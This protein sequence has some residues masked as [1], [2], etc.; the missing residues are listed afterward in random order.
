MDVEDIIQVDTG[1]SKG[2]IGFILGKFL[3]KKFGV[4]FDDFRIPKLNIHSYGADKCYNFSIEISCSGYMHKATLTQL[5]R[6]GV[7]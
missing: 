6:G 4:K 1:I 5:I 2:I 7:K 3:E